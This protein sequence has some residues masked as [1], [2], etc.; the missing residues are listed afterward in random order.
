MQ[1]T[2]TISDIS[3]SNNTKVLICPKTQTPEVVPSS[4]LPQV[5]DWSYLQYRLLTLL[6]TR[7]LNEITKNQL[8]ILNKDWVQG[9]IYV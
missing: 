9:N 5:Y 3:N 4:S 2:R 8:D 1:P 6:K 7:V